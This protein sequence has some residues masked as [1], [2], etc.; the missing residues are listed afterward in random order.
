MKKI[1]DNIIKAYVLEN[2]IK[3]SGK[4]S[5]QSVLSGLFAEGLQKAQIKEYL[6]KIEE[7]IKKVNSLKPIEQKEDF[8]LLSKLI[9]KRKIRTGLPELPKTS[10]TNV[11]MRF[12]PFPSGPLHIGN[13]RTLVLN[14]SYVNQYNGKLILVIDDTIGSEKKPIEPQAYNLIK[15]GVKLLKIKLSREPI[16]KSSRLQIYYKYAKKL[17]EKDF[18]YICSCDKEK[19]KRLKI[20]GIECSC[21]A[22]PLEIQRKKWK[23]M[24]KAKEGSYCARLKTNMQDPD[25]AFRDRIMF[26]IS[27]RSHAL[28]GRKYR[29]Y[30]LLDFSWAIDDHLLGITHILRGMELAME[31]KV[32]KFIWDIFNWSHP[33]IIYNGHFSINGIKISKSKGTKEVKSGEYIGWNDPRT[34]SLQSLHERGILPES[35]KKF[36]LDMGIRKTNITVPIDVLYSI[37][38]KLLNKAPKYFFIKNPQKIE[39]SGCPSLDAEPPT[40]NSEEY[41]ITQTVQEFLI[42]FQEFKSM[43]SQNYR[44][45]NLFNFRSE[46]SP[47]NFSFISPEPDPKL[48]TKSIHWLPINEE[49][50][51]VEVRMPDNQIIK[52]V[53]EPSLKKLKKGSIIQLERFGFVRLHKKHKDNKLEFWFAHN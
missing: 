50:I 14:D 47:K 53:G 35:I 22:Y 23:E 44:L 48:K 40:S 49:N 33:Q 4:A 51:K 34:W 32:E 6:P 1:S 10:N 29:V 18:L 52:G 42:P 15:E 26:R 39:I 12:A 13:A 21:R 45:I 17:I 2:A 16:L 20:E 37:N 38:R 5:P 30:P 7:V 41:Q 3:Y 36:I 46:G 31:T 19:I 24:F 27:D 25:P 8:S 28:L 9:S 43:Q 11:V